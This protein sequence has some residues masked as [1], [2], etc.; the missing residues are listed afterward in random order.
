MCFWNDDY[1]WT[2][3]VS[4]EEEFVASKP[5]KCQECYRLIPAGETMVHIWMQQYEECHACYDGECECPEG[6][7][8]QCEEPVFGET[9]DYH[10]CQ[11]CDKFLMAVEAAE[12]EEGCARHESRPG[13]GAMASDIMDGD[14]ENIKRYFKRA[15]RDFPELKASG[16]L[17]RLGKRICA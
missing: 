14:R 15:L 16:Y 2:A 12:V 9:F 4:E 8:C 1:D 17:T 11:E 5:T 13:L 6:R 3:E 10:R 7:C